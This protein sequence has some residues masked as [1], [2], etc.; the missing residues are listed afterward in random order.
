M[1]RING[2]P[3]VWHALPAP[4]A[5]ELGLAVAGFGHLEDMLK[6]AIFAMERDRL[7]GAITEGQ[8]RDWQRRMDH[9]AADSLGTLIDRLERVSQR[10][11]LE[12]R[13][14]IE[15]LRETRDWRNLL[16][17]AVWQ[18]SGD[19]WQPLFANNRGD[20]FIGTISAEDLAAIRAMTLDGARRAGRLI[21]Q[22]TDDDS[23]TASD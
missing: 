17:H 6:R 15:Q 11:D 19:G 22:V 12:D 9:V 16:C 21:R 10:L 4:L 23:W 13:P 20:R 1:A 5:A 7:S 2:D 14:L 18:P 8:F 3:S